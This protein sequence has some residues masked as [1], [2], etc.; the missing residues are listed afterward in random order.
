MKIIV[1]SRTGADSVTTE[2]ETDRNGT[3]EIRPGLGE[4]HSLFG[5]ADGMATE[6]HL[7]RTIPESALGNSRKVNA[8]HGLHELS[9]DTLPVPEGNGISLAELET[10]EAEQPPFFI[11]GA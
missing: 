1:L 2:L 3:I 9:A 4:T 11:T 6:F 8:V 5:D 7:F 10:L